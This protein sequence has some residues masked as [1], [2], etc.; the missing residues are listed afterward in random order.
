MKRNPETL[1]LA[2]D[3]AAAMEACAAYVAVKNPAVRDPETA[4][5]LLRPIMTAA[6]SGDLE[7]GFDEQTRSSNE[8]VEID[9]HGSSPVMWWIQ[10]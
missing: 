8:R 6:T 1:N 5:R 2:M 3:Y 9:R 10:V 7:F 4:Y